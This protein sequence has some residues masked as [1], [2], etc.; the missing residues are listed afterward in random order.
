MT[1]LPLSF[2]S[3]YETRYRTSAITNILP[4]QTWGLPA[5]FETSR[6]TVFVSE[7]NLHNYANAYLQVAQSD[8]QSSAH[9]GAHPSGAEQT[10]SL[11]L[12]PLGGKNTGVV[13]EQPVSSRMPF[14]TPWRVMWIG[15]AGERGL[16]VPLES[17]T[18]ASLNEPAAS[19]DWSWVHP[20]KV[21]FQWRNGYT[22]PGEAF[23]PPEDVLQFSTLKSTWIFAQ[24]TGS[25]VFESMVANS[26]WHGTA[27]RFYP[28]MPKRKIS[29]YRWTPSKCRHFSAMP[30]LAAL[31]LGFCSPVMR[32]SCKI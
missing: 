15:E 22:M 27:D 19:Q 4:G 12:P 8:V 6:A 28:T 20:G 24:I 13:V 14:K 5:V 31:K 9:S 1:A 7:A 30:K 16:R 21:L 10:L 29:S 32:S 3:A 23:D 25:S 26:N 18:L 2:G 17:T 11:T